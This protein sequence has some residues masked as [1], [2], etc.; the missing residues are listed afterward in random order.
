MDPTHYETKYY[1]EKNRQLLNIIHRNKKIDY[2]DEKNV[3][4]REI[5]KRNQ[6]NTFNFNILNN[7][8]RLRIEPRRK[9][10]KLKN[11]TFLNKYNTARIDIKNQGITHEKRNRNTVEID[12]ISDFNLDYYYPNWFNNQEG[13]GLSIQSKSNCLQFDITCIGD[14]E[15]NIFLRS[16]D[17]RLNQKKIPIYINYTK[18]LVNNKNI[19]KENK[20][21][22]HSNFYL[23][24]IK[25]SN[26]QRL[27]LYLE[28]API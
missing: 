20:I 3:N 21:V 17:F 6:I 2:N 16:V 8:N 26:N 22:S 28:W 19:L 10:I 9:I 11:E 15:L 18:F 4:F 13:T 5:K 25:V 14:G 12:N 23:H 7:E 24:K 27:T 1:L